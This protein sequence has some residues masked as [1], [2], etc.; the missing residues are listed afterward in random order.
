MLSF[1]CKYCCKWR[2]RFL[3]GNEAGAPLN[4]NTGCFIGEYLQWQ[5]LL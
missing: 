1:H 5:L 3:T 4:A 2:L